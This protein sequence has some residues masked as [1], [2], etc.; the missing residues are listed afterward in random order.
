MTPGLQLTFDDGPNSEWTPQILDLLN[1]HHVKATF[2]VIGQ[3]ILG[4]ENLLRRMVAYGHTI[5]NHSLT[6]RKLTDLDIVA[7]RVELEACSYLIEHA[8]GVR[9]EMYRAP[10]FLHDQVTDVQAE[11]LGMRHVGAD[12]DPHDWELGLP[13]EIVERIHSRYPQPGALVCLHD[14]LPPGGGNGTASRAA[15]VEAVRLLLENG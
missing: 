8:C 5:G 14:G 15:T 9:P 10:Y 12:I 11:S 6:H 4:H 7:Q 2:F 13:E 3:H 1:A